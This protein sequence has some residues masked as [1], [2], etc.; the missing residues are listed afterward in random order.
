MTGQN[1]RVIY[2]VQFSNMARLVTFVL[3]TGTIVFSSLVAS[4][5]HYLEQHAIGSHQLTTIDTIRD[6]LIS[7]SIIDEVLDDF[8]PTYSV[9]VS[10]P[11][12]HESV[13]LGNEATREEKT[14]VPV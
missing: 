10:Y 5:P 6:I 11:A 1:P 13:Q 9:S 2:S 8:T 14:M 12:A 7:N 4:F 3:L